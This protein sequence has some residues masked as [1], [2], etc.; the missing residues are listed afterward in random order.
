MLARFA[1]VIFVEC[2][3]H[4]QHQVEAARGVGGVDV[5]QAQTV[6]GARSGDPAGV[7]AFRRQGLMATLAHETDEI[8]QQHDFAHAP[9]L[10]AAELG[11]AHVHA[12]AAGGNA[13]PVLYEAADEIAGGGDPGRIVV[14][15]GTTDV[16][17]AQ[18]V[19]EGR[20][21]RGEEIQRHA[22]R[23]SQFVDRMKAEEAQI[24]MRVRGQ[25]CHRIA[26]RPQRPP[27]SLHHL[28]CGPVRDGAHPCL[29]RN[30]VM[31]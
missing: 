11:E 28:L 20:E 3:G 30:H 16:R 10:D 26:A 7:A 24:G 21:E 17:P 29:P 27:Q 9:V 15:A 5:I 14:L 1:P 6:A 31:L 8:D 22:F 25:R 2:V 12:A 18:Q 23:A 4:G 13:K 19:R